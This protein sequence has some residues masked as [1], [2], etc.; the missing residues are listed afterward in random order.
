MTTTDELA[1]RQTVFREV[2]DNIASLTSLLTETGYQLFICE[3]SDTACAE[4]LDLTAEEYEAVRAYGARFVVKPGHQLAGIERVVDG[5]G[6]F[7]VV[8]KIGQAADIAQA[9]YPTTD[10]RQT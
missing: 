2:N 5:N 9:D 1:C 7:L 4:S 10:E 6:R 8:E 3:C